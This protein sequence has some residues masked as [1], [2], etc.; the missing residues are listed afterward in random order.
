MSEKNFQKALIHLYANI[1]RYS[2]YSDAIFEQFVLSSSEKHALNELMTSQR[3]G[4][5][6]FS[7]QLQDKRRRIIR[8]ALP[9]SQ[10]MIGRQLETLLDAHAS[11]PTSEGARDP[12]DA[13]RSFAEYV[14]AHIDNQTHVSKELEFIRFEAVLASLT[15]RPP[16]TYSNAPPLLHLSTDMRLSLEGDAAL[17]S[18]TYD[19]VAAMKDPALLETPVRLSRPCWFFMFQARGGDVRILTVAPGLARVLRLFQSGLSLGDVLLTFE[20][21][22]QKTDASSGIEKLLLM[23]APFSAEGHASGSWSTSSGQIIG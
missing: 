20:C 14:A 13:V 2:S 19:V 5:L 21:E 8:Y 23:G 22:T 4:L 12:A 7:Q 10:E 15:L 9:R 17:V 18:C 6:L 16:A 11:G 1:D 3:H